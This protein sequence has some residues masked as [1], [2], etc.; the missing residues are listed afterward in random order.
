MDEKG[1]RELVERSWNDE[2]SDLEWGHLQSQRAKFGVEVR[3][4]LP[5]LLGRLDALEKAG[6]DVLALVD[7]IALPR[8]ELA[9]VAKRLRSLLSE[10][11]EDS[12]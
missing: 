2:M 4:A 12:R 6:K 7:D 1:L 5:A 9:S 3:T 10:A 8:S 11:K